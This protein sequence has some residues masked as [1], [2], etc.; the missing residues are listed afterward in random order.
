MKRGEPLSAAVEVFRGKPEDVSVNA[1]RM[2]DTPGHAATFIDRSVSF[3]ESETYILTPR[4][5]V[6]IAIPLKATLHGLLDGRLLI[7]PKVDWTPTAGGKTY[8]AGSLLSVD[9]AALKGRSGASASGPDLRPRPA[10]NPGGSG[11][12]QVAHD[13]GDV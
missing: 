4:G 3:F 6:R 11:D 10:R 13:R 8:G 5:A 2:H 9:L 7:E 1:F 12:H